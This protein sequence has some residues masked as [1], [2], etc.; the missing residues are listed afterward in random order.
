MKRLILL[1]IA[2]LCLLAACAGSHSG[3]DLAEVAESTLIHADD[4]A[5]DFTLLTVGRGA[6]TLSEHNGKVVLVNF[7]ATWCPPCR[8]EMPHLRD[9]IQKRFGGGD[10]VLVS[11]AREEGADDV[12]PFMKKYGARWIFALD[13]KREAFARYA[14]AYIPRNF[15]VD[16]HGK[17]IYQSQGFE[18][19]EFAEMEQV[20]AAALGDA[21]RE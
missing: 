4:A 6:F 11:V 17:V 21:H 16:R 10:F 2:L 7:F 20:I 3:D 19:E 5:P 13:E 8:A 15:V 12:A 18:E 1:P 14:T 9:R